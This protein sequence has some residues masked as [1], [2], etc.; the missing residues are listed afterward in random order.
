MLKK[1]KM[2]CIG[3]R[4]SKN[5][6]KGEASSSTSNKCCSPN[7]KVSFDETTHLIPT[8]EQVVKHEVATQTSGRSDRRTYV[9]KVFFPVKILGWNY[10]K[11]EEGKALR[12]DNQVD[13]IVELLVDY[14]VHDSFLAECSSNDVKI[15]AVDHDWTKLSYDY[16]DYLFIENTQYKNR[17]TRLI[18]QLV[19]PNSVCFL[20]EA[21]IY[22]KT[23]EPMRELD[24]VDDKARFTY[25][26]LENI[27]NAPADDPTIIPTA[28]EF[29]DIFETLENLYKA[30]D[31]K[32]H[33]FI[34]NIKSR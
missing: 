1:I 17:E 4:S 12:F 14:D 3:K 33:Q 2:N 22:A 24:D 7:L 34:F 29:C 21:E 27:L 16:E 6:K 32:I 19:V 26:K 15:R 13:T 11:G 5:D 18:V 30:Y 25:S 10:N 20:L 23:K 9:E 8:A 31:L 28:L